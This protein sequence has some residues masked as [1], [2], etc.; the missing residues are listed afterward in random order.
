MVAMDI[1]ELNVVLYEWLAC[2]GMYMIIV[3]IVSYSVEL[4]VVQNLE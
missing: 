3:L 2:G 1:D 4:C